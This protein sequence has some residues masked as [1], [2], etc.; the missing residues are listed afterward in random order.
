MT[1][2]PQ[3]E[4]AAAKPIGH[5]LRPLR[6]LAVYALAGAPAVFLFAAVIDLMGRDFATQTR[7]G[8]GSF[9]N[10]E[11]VLFPIAAVL[12]AHW[13][14]PRHPKARLVTL[15]ALAEYAV[16]SFFGV[17]FGLLFGVSGLAAQNAALAFTALLTRVAWLAVLAVPAYAVVQIYLGLYAVPKP[18]P[19]PGVYGQPYGQPQYGTVPPGYAQFQPGAAP[20]SGQPYAPPVATQPFQAQQAPYGAYPPVPPVWGQ[21]QPPPEAPAATQVV[22][23]T[24]PEPPAATQVVPPAP[25]D[26]T[27]VL[28]PERP[29]FGPAGQDPP[30]Q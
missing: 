9:V 29:G 19:Q 10:L 16:A 28:P 21:P 23:P 26:S 12:L 15:V 25:A 20:G 1:T 30:R 2:P 8:F 6:D 13:V 7:Y 5:F 11:T 18:K 17:I 27:T 24:T 4:P 22:P 14:L 3:P